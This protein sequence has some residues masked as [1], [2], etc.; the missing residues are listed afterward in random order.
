VFST[1]VL[2]FVIRFFRGFLKCLG[3]FP[4]HQFIESGDLDVSSCFHLFGVESIAFA[5][6]CVSVK[7]LVSRYCECSVVFSGF[8][9]GHKPLVG[10]RTSHPCDLVFLEG[11]FG[12][13]SF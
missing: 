2:R 6:W 10:S 3:S 1:Q 12:Q 7:L 5:L 8:T 13:R 4:N 11:C 9:E